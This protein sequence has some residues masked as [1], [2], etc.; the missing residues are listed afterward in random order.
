MLQLKPRYNLIF[1]NLNEFK[2]I[3]QTHFNTICVVS[4][5]FC[6]IQRTS[7]STLR[8]IGGTVV[9]V[10]ALAVLSFALVVGLLMFT[11][12]EG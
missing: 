6:F 5:L 8:Y 2:F 3:L 9:G 1:T 4:F 12:I 7:T 10:S 11:G